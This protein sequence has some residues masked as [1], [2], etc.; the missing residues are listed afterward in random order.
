MV[1]GRT[2]LSRADIYRRRMSVRPDQAFRI[3]ND[4]VSVNQTQSSEFTP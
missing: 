3:M 4:R 1:F 2:E